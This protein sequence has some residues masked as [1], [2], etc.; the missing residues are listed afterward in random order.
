[1]G[2]KVSK[3]E[4]IN[5]IAA[6]PAFQKNGAFNAQLY[7]QMLQANRIMP[8]DFEDGIKEELGRREFMRR[9]AAASFSANS[10]FG[11]TQAA[12][13]NNAEIAAWEPPKSPA[14]SETMTVVSICRKTTRNMRLRDRLPRD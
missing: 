13:P 8:Q 5:A 11:T 9:A 4:V 3:D 6:I 2:I 14:T 10:P 1:M 12:P 7:Q